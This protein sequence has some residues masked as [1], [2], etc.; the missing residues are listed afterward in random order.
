MST[1][2]TTTHDRGPC[3]CG[4]GTIIQHVTTQDNPW[5]SADS[6]YSIDCEECRNKWHREN[7]APFFVL[8]SSETEHIAAR[9]QEGAAYAAFDALSERLIADYFLSFPAKNKAREHA[10]M[11]RLNLT[12]M[13]YRQYL[14]HRRSEESVASACDGRRNI[15][16]ILDQAAACGMQS[17]AAELLDRYEA[18]KKLSSEAA[19][20]IERWRIA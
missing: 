1:S 7:E 16:W 15:D 14:A 12:S 2:E 18:S 19:R 6:S 3:P 20:R 5:S 11:E 13:T 8:R 17:K 4:N 9:Q 10:E